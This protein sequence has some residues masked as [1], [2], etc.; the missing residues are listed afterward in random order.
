MGAIAMDM[1]M[2]WCTWKVGLAAVGGGIVW[3]G[4]FLKFLQ[5][6]MREARYQRTTLLLQLE[7]DYSKAPHVLKS[8]QAT[9]DQAAEDIVS[10][11]GKFKKGDLK[12]VRREVTD[13]E[14]DPDAIYSRPAPPEFPVK[15]TVIEMF[16]A[17]TSN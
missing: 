9:L 3:T 15:R 6:Q 10:K 4:C 14:M 2:Q 12:V 11:L 5:H 8:D 16:F 13:A 1:L 17:P 7:V